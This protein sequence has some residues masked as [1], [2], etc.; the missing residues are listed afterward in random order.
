[1]LVSVLCQVGLGF[2]FLIPSYL[3]LCVRYLI[4]TWHCFFEMRVFFLY[5]PV[6]LILVVVCV[7]CGC[8]RWT[9]FQNLT[10]DNYVMLWS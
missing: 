3:G 9:S 4:P 6:L 10:L 5:G 2:A 8:K 1:M 7:G